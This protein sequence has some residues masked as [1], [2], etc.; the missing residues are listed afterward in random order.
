MAARGGGA[1][2]TFA[3]YIASGAGERPAIVFLYG[4]QADIVD[5]A[6]AAVARRMREAQP[7]LAVYDRAAAGDIAQDPTRLFDHFASA[8]LFG[9]ETLLRIDGVAETHAKLLRAFFAEAD[10]GASRNR[11]IFASSDLKRGSALLGAARGHDDAIVLSA[12]DAGLDA[13]TVAEMARARGLAPSAPEIISRLAEYGSANGP[14][15]LELA[16]EKLALAAAPDGALDEAVFDA[17]L[18]ES[19]GVGAD[20]LAER[21][22]AG[23]H[24]GLLAQLERLRAEGETDARFVAQLSRICLDVKRAQP[25]QSAGRTR[26]L[27]WKTEKIVRA[28]QQRLDRLTDRLERA[29]REIQQAE[30]M[31]RSSEPL[32][33]IIAERLCLR[34]ARCFA[35]SAR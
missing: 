31:L 9:D 4:S 14:Q 34:L 6:A 11:L 25:G 30:R 8:G 19:G 28:A 17:T 10:I 12:Y 29:L 20:A 15:L 23:D 33:P 3:S 26:P 13:A 1:D 32:A 5:G 16:L 21:L 35:T 24:A 22:F 27:F 2:P 18:P 7:G